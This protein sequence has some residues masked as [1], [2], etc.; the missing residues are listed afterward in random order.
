LPDCKGG[1]NDE[2]KLGK[3][4]LSGSEE[5]QGLGDT[6]V[7]K[8]LGPCAETTGRFFLHTIVS[9]KFDICQPAPQSPSTPFDK[10]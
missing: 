5:D 2:S 9:V 7:G 10:L 6:V 3:L 4:D 8:D 1:P